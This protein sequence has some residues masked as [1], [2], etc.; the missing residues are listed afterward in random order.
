M[1]ESMTDLLADFERIKRAL[2]VAEDVDGERASKRML[3][4][5]A[6]DIVKLEKSKGLKLPPSYQEFLLHSDGWARFWGAMWIAGTGGKAHKYV[7]GQI[8]HWR[9]YL[10]KPHGE[11]DLDFDRHFIIGADDNGGFL[12]F[13]HEADARGEREVLDMPRGFVENRWPT[14]RAFAEAQRKYRAH[15]LQK[16][17]A[18]KQRSSPK[19]RS[20]GK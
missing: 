17:T 19:K 2:D 4:A 5:K 15:D 18:P 16:L 1:A 12:A 10:N 9:K 3:P 8:K 20:V 14:F 7:Q 13:S 11:D 6:T